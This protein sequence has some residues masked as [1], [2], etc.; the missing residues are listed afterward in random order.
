MTKKKFETQDDEKGEVSLF[1]R[2]VELKSAA[3]ELRRK[4]ADALDQSDKEIRESMVKYLPLLDA[5]EN[6][7]E[8]T[9]VGKLLATLGDVEKRLKGGSTKELA[10][11]EVAALAALEKELFAWN[12]RRAGQNL[13]P[14]AEAVALLDLH[15]A[16]HQQFIATAI[17]HPEWD[18]PVAGHA[19]IKDEDEKARVKEAWDNLRDGKGNILISRASEK[20]RPVQAGSKL[21]K[22]N[23]GTEED[24]KRFRV[25][26]L[27][28]FSRLLATPSGRYLVGELNAGGKAVTV[29][30]TADGDMAA[31]SGTGGSMS[32]DGERGAGATTTVYMPSG[33]RA[34][35][36][37][38]LAYAK[39]G[40][41][42]YDPPFIGL[43]HEL[44]HA[45]HFA[46]GKGRANLDFDDR[47]TWDDAEE[48][49]TIFKGK[50]TE[51]PLRHQCGLATPRYGH[52]EI[53]LA[54]EV[55]RAF[56]GALEASQKLA[57]ENYRRKVEEQLKSLGYDRGR[58]PTPRSW[59]TW[60]R[61]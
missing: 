8:R 23:S 61:R 15:Q 53:A 31:Q 25:E 6:N 48:Y 30:M 29:S 16:V 12:D 11:D 45:L 43:G 34:R 36:S 58:S 44:I 17:E 38:D 59:S 10:R 2:I 19:E 54:G 21:F 42:L 28:N 40:N 24:A 18:P 46:R 33:D 13:P 20:V 27:A 26:T 5:P 37:N 51:N 22:V 7:P 49:R 56:A 32:K 9:E 55:I 3:Y 35:A 41:S 52:K 60:K 57:D 39:N 47:G 4:K 1:G 50:T 14:S